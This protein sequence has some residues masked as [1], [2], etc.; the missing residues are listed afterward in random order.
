[1]IGEDFVDK[2]VIK[3]IEG[4]TTNR[5]ARLLVRSSLNPTRT[6]ANVLSVRAPWSRDTRAG[7]SSYV[8]AN[9]RRNIAGLPSTTKPSAAEP[10]EAVLVPP[11]DFAI[12]FQPE[13]LW[14]GDKDLLCIGGGANAGIRMGPS[15][16]IVADIGGCKMVGLEKN[17]SGDS[18]TY[19]AGPRW[20]SRIRGPWSAHVQVLAGGNKVT[21]ERMNPAMKQLLEA[22]A[23]RG[24]TLPPSH[25]EYTES[26]ESNG[27]AL[28]TGGGVN[29][30]LTRALTIRVADISYRHNW[31]SALWG[32]DLS[33]TLKVSSGIVLRMGTW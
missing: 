5:Y 13:R 31:T 17:L 2:S 7:V 25:E 8:A 16:Q 14:G 28:S 10:V 18:L 19:A 4:A 23:V 27:F 6:F 29:Y 24:N 9:D 20:I 30:E 32:R 26:K 3:R 33:N 11:F 1:M 22:A 12:T 21:E 15:W